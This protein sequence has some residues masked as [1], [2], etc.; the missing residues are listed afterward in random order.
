M[1]GFHTLH[2]AAVVCRSTEHCAAPAC[3]EARVYHPWRD[4]HANC[5]PYCP[6]FHPAQSLERG[7]ELI[8]LFGAFKGVRAGKTL[9]QARRAL[10]RREA[11]KAADKK[12]D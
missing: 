10:K 12:K 8:C 5:P 11:E 9:M 2:S 6:H 4:C 1:A 7:A 3:S